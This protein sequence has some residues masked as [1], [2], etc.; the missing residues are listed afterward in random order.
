MI[1]LL[2]RPLLDRRPGPCPSMYRL[3]TLR[4]YSATVL[5]F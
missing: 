4:C 5:L 1:G 3:P 2:G